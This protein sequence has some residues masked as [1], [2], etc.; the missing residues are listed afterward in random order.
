MDTTSATMSGMNWV[1][2]H[3][4]ADGESSAPVDEIQ[5]PTCGEPVTPR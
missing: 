4:G 2:E 1:C 5:C 3:C